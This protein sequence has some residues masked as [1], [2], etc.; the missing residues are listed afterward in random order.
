[1]TTEFTIDTGD[2]LYEDLGSICQVIYPGCKLFYDGII[3][4]A[5]K[6]SIDRK[7]DME[8]FKKK[9]DECRGDCK[10]K[11]K[12]VMDTVICQLVKINGEYYIK[13]G[14][15]KIALFE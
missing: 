4:G 7:I 6:Y 9:I 11:R 2:D 3:D 5:H 1:M 12:E 10:K 14:D 8:Y 13:D 15:K